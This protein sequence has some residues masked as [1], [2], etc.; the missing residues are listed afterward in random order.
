[1]GFE[2]KFP[3]KKPSKLY[4][5][6]NSFLFTVIVTWQA[7]VVGFENE[8]YAA[9]Y[10]RSPADN[11]TSFTYAR[12]VY[13]ELKADGSLGH[14]QQTRSYDGTDQAEMIEMIQKDSSAVGEELEQ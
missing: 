2:Q 5:V 6:V 7:A 1:M 12:P 13:G 14:N 4:V 11:S 3:S 8:C 10:K 9:D